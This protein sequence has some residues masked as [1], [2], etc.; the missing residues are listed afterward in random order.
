MHLNVRHVTTY[1]YEP[2]AN[3]IGLRLKLFPAN[4]AAQSCSDWSVTVNGQ[5]VEPLLTD[6]AGDRSGLWHA[7]TPQ[8]RV[9]IIATGTFET[10][11][12]A[13]VLRNVREAMP[14]AVYLRETEITEP[15]PAIRALAG[16]IDADEPLARLHALSEAVTEAVTYT[17]GATDAATTAAE[18]IVLTEGVCQDQ[19]HVFISAARCMG[20][21]ARYVAG[22]LLDP[23]LEEDSMEQTHAWAEA[24]VGSLGWVGFDITNQLCPTDAYIRLA[25]GF[26]AVDAA[27]IRGTVTGT[28]EQTL[29]TSVQINQSV[30]QSQQ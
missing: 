2:A 13:G 20:I 26:D 23:D 4:S 28:T 18:A 10:T 3:G 7:A 5:T 22:Y 27:P 15:S 25:S 24:H 6:A 9:E 11:D 8:D 29:S 16:T 30:G 17:S 19:A 1:V 14:P 12:T 21:P